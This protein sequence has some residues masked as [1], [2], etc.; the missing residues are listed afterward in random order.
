MP[1][2]AEE[3]RKVVEIVG[4]LNI[5]LNGTRSSTVGTGFEPE[6]PGPLLV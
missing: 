5:G 3:L 4:P 1:L 6:D 2:H